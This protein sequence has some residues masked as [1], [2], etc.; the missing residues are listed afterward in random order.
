MRKTILQ[1]IPATDWFALFVNEQK[2]VVETTP[3]TC[4]ALCKADK[5][6]DNEY[7]RGM[8]NISEGV[9]IFIDSKS[10][11]HCYLHKREFHI[12]DDIKKELVNHLSANASSPSFGVLS[13]LNPLT[14]LGK[15][16]RLL[17]D[18][19]HDNEF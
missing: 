2:G 13:P 15:S 6:D 19:I 12:V 3:L 7:V 4:W 5:D 14:E 1:I 18:Y 9:V 8:G 16:D 10:D 17:G 11:F